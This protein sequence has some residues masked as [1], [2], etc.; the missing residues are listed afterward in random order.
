MNKISQVLQEAI[1]AHES[2]FVENK[3][4]FQILLPLTRLL[5]K[6]KPVEPA[7][8]A[9][10]THRSLEEIRALLQF[11]EVEVDQQGRFVGF[12]LS[13][14]PTP[15]QFHLGERTF[16]TW[17]AL[18]TL[19]LPAALGCTAQVVSTYSPPGTGQRG[20]FGSPS[21]GRRLRSCASRLLYGGTF[22]CV[23]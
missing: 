23:A 21:G 7:H 20:R 22:L 1:K 12:S 3:E 5:T 8:L 16:Y 10:E 13:L 4:Q 2:F 17:C 18:D 14:V 15:H 19:A 11:S 9:A 6:G